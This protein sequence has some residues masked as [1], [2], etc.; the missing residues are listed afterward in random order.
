M[1]AW[2]EQTNK[3]INKLIQNNQLSLSAKSTSQVL[4]KAMQKD[5]RKE[6]HEAQIQN[7]GLPDQCR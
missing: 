4:Q 3:Q 7:P 5:C 1:K 6:C 2:Y